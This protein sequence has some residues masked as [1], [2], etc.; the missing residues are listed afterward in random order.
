[1]HATATIPK[2]DTM[3]NTR[4]GAAYPP[5]ACMSGGIMNVSCPTHESGK[6][7]RRTAVVKPLPPLIRLGYAATSQPMPHGARPANRRADQ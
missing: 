3:I 6:I 7:N 2:D 1:M 5:N 4:R